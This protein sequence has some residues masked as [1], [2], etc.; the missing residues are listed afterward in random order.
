MKK[1]FQRIRDLALPYQDKRNDKGH[2]AVTLSYAQ[3]LVKLENG[4][5]NIVIP[6]II[7]HDVGWSQA[8][9]EYVDAVFKGRSSREQAW[10]VVTQHQN[11][12]V[13]LAADMLNRVAYP[14]DKAREI[15]EIILQHDTRMGFISKNEG[16]VRDADKL[17][18]FSRTGFAADIKRSGIPAK[19]ELERLEKEIT[20]PRYL[21]SNSARKIAREE[22]ES[23]KINR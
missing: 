5:E 7:L 6:A 15:L 9:P 20:N 12:S 8:K 21:Y 16:L 10:A 13:R 11:E 1:I 3:K 18:R 17:W 22:L 2:H 4:D 14:A 19:A 23:R